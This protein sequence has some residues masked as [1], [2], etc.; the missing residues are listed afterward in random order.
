MKLSWCASAC[1]PIVP[2]IALL[3]TVPGS[4]Q[5]PPKFYWVVENNNRVLS[6]DSAQDR[7]EYEM[8]RAL[9]CSGEAVSA[10]APTTWFCANAM[11][12]QAAKA[13]RQ[14]KVS[15]RAVTPTREAFCSTSRFKKDTTYWEPFPETGRDL[16]TAWKP[17]TLR[18]ER[19]DGYVGGRLRTVVAWVPDATTETCAW[20]LAGVD[21]DYVSGSCHE[22]KRSVELGRDYVLSL[23]ITRDGLAAPIESQRA[24]KVEDVFLVALG[25]SYSSGEGNPHV[26]RK[27]SILDAWWDRRCH[28]SL[29]SFSSLAVGISA[30]LDRHFGDAKKHSFT[31]M[32]F[33]CSGAE[34]RGEKSGDGGV[35]TQYEGRETP[36]QMQTLKTLFPKSELGGAYAGKL[37]PSQIKQLQDN[38]C[39]GAT[40]PCANYRKPDYITMTIGGNDVGFGPLLREFIKGCPSS[41]TDKCPSALLDTR[42]AK[43]ERQFDELATAINAIGVNRRVLL[44]EYIDLTRSEQHKFCD[45]FS[46]SKTLGPKYVSRLGGL[47]TVQPTTFGYGVDA[48]KA[49][50]AHK[51]VLG[52]LN[53]LLKKVADKY[54]QK[55][56]LYISGVARRSE[57]RGWC[58]SPSWF[59]RFDDSVAKQGT[60]PD[61]ARPHKLSD[62]LTTGIA[63]P[64]IYGHNFINWRVR[65]Q[66]ELDGILPPG[67]TQGDG[68]PATACE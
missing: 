68:K 63:H 44:A 53:R 35:L 43:L 24:V 12:A 54:A 36:R 1:L 59:I 25:D 18:Y 6:S 56:W 14:A 57:I 27:S 19:G 50:M 34:I 40:F 2:M 37:L 47:I 3:A 33:A 23:R 5:E 42:F 55:G 21:P 29:L 46:M 48:Q 58:A 10:T 30:M 22:V 13:A 66:L 45:D 8:C 16:E 15:G 64:N 49:E 39:P 38:L 41:S 28:R 7:F 51:E 67:S 52:R 62:E 17:T 26:L 20:K 32:N 9:D 4:A 60:L 61:E 65:C 11:G 31:Y